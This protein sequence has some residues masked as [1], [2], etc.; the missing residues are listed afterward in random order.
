MIDKFMIDIKI[1]DSLITFLGSA[2]PFIV[3]FSSNSWEE[4]KE[5]NVAGGLT[6]SNKGFKI[7]YEQS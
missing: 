3:T 2:V 4:D 6:G 5:L 1:F 7:N